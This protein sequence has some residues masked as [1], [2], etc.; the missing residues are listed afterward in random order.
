MIAPGDR[1]GEFRYTAPM[2][3]LSAV[4]TTM[5]IPTSPERDASTTVGVAVTERRIGEIWSDPRK[6]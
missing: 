4:P 1:A 3:A 2:P 5:P 6:L